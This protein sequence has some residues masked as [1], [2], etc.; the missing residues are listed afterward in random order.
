KLSIGRSAIPLAGEWKYKVESIR[1]AS[2]S[3]GPNSYP[4]LLYNAML[5][6]LIPFAMKGVIWYQ[7]EANA[8][9]AYQ[10]R[11]A[12]PLMI[13]DW[14]KHWNQGNFPF[15]FVQLASFNAENG[16]SKNGSAWAELR[17]AQTMTLSLP[18]TGMAV[19]TDI[20]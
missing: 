14:R 16:N 13:T 4:T 7:G 3:V 19:T 11:Q 12:F 9:R 10:Y 2:G 6:P 17:E 8:G 15:Y 5:S 20:G 1:T 18:N